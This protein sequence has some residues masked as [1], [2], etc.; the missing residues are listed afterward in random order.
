MC[1][2]IWRVQ[3]VERA[4]DLS[5]VGFQF[6]HTLSMP[7]HGRHLFC[8]LPIHNSPFPH[9]FLPLCTPGKWEVLA[10]KP[11]PLP[12]WIEFRVDKGPESDKQIFSPG[13]VEMDWGRKLA[14]ILRPVVGHAPWGR[15]R[16]WNQE[17][18]GCPVLVPDHPGATFPSLDFSLYC[19]N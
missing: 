15:K 19:C 8:I 18:W 7:L 13:N 17:S 3:L 6:S 5:K 14:I 4:L 9:N 12:L 11:P 2:K 16:W 10:Q 1:L